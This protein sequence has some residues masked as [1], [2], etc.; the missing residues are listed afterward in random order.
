MSRNWHA[1][2]EKG[3]ISIGEGNSSFTRQVTML[4]PTYKTYHKHSYVLWFGG[5]GATYLHVYEDSLES[6]LEECA[7][8][9]ADHAPGHIMTFGSDEHTDLV[10][11]AC[12]ERGLPFA[13]DKLDGQAGYLARCILEDEL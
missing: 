11:E 10:K 2:K 3:G 5:C 9:L 6:A 1:R 8:W 12:E 13:P 4:N 7:S